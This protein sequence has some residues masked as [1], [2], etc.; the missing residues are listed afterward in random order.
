MQGAPKV[1]KAVWELR[2]VNVAL[3]HW[4]VRGCSAYSRYIMSAKLMMRIQQC[5]LYKIIL[6]GLAK[7]CVG[8]SVS[9]VSAFGL[10][11][12]PKMEPHVGLPAQCG[13]CF[14]LPPTPGLVL[15]MS[16]S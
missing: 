6:R 9:W 1:W 2:E 4:A 15:S 11:L 12:D 10:G 8:C 13:V 5:Y 3:L 16:P 7:G 14:S